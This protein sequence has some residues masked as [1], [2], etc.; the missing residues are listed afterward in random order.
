MVFL[1]VPD[2]K[3]VLLYE[4]PKTTVPRFRENGLG[5]QVSVAYMRKI[6]NN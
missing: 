6:I 4:R 5:E 1:P 3:Y 2:P